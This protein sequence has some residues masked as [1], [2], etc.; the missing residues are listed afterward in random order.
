MLTFWENIYKFP[1]FLMGVLIGFFL[2][3]FG[4][5]FKQLKNKKSKIVSIV[6]L[7]GTIRIVY[8]IIKKMNGIE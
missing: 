7:A 6:I 3:T 2:T 4:P 8:T 1:R 5:I